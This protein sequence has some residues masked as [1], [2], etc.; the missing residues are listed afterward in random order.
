MEAEPRTV[1][2]LG[3]T[4]LLVK[5]ST[6]TNKLGGSIM[7]CLRS[8]NRVVVRAIGANAVNQAI[9]GTIVASHH[10][11]LE[12]WGPLSFYPS[13]L[14]IV[15]DGDQRTAVCL[16]IVLAQQALAS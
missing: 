14:D 2:E 5:S 10:C 3:A 8:G 12:G 11:E 15:A 16:S 7:H 1:E 9:K 6:S 4:V 13:F